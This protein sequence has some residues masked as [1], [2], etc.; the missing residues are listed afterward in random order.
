[1]MSVVELHGEGGGRYGCSA[2]WQG[3]KAWQ[4]RG[5]KGSSLCQARLLLLLAASTLSTALVAGRQKRQCEVPATL[6]NS[7]H[8]FARQHIAVTAY[9][10]ALRLLQASHP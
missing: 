1:M 2:P 5:S 8:F 9:T 3:K 6:K 4:Y 10:T 7:P